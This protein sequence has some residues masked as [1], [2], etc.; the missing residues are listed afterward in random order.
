MT[1]FDARMAAES[2][3]GRMSLQAFNSDVREQRALRFERAFDP[4]AIGELFDIAR[5]ESLFASEAL[6]LAY[7]D[8]FDD[9]Q[10][11]RLGAIMIRRQVTKLSTSQSSGMQRILL[12]FEH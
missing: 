12:G 9:S 10:L 5:L 4:D 11:T 8:V 7:V 1:A 6:P 2:L 3:T